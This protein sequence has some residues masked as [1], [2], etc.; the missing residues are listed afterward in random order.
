MSFR[1]MPAMLPLVEELTPA[2]AVAT[3]LRALAD[4]PGVILFDSARQDREAG[5]YS[6]LAADPFD[7]EQLDRP[8]FVGR[9]GPGPFAYASSFQSP[10]S[11]TR[12]EARDQTVPA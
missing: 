5:R 10:A 8:H 1:K 3:A 9:D 7:F 6:F 12:A 2:P 4:W 11:P